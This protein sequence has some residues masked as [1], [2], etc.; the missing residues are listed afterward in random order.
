M[1]ETFQDKL[2]QQDKNRAYYGALT[3]IHRTKRLMEKLLGWECFSSWQ[4]YQ[5]KYGAKEYAL[6]AGQPFT[7]P[8][9]VAFCEQSTRSEN[10][11][12]RVFS[13][14]H[15]DLQVFR[16]CDSMSDAWIL[17]QA[18]AKQEDV[19]HNGLHTQDIFFTRIRSSVRTTIGEKENAPLTLQEIAALTP[20]DVCEAV[21]KAFQHIE[22]AKQAAPQETNE[23]AGENEQ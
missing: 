12:W 21:Y 13:P 18:L 19:E 15:E 9:H 10:W 4:D 2:N 3:W 5:R 6:G 22:E 23:Q 16:P 8:T 1:P 11:E 14:D 17:V 7:T 20:L